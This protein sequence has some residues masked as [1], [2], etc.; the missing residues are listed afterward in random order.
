ML[1]IRQ[2][3]G[4]ESTAM[5]ILRLVFGSVEFHSV[6]I[7]AAIGLPRVAAGIMLPGCF[8]LSKFPTPQWFI[9]DVGRLGF[10]FPTVFAWA[11]VLTEV[12]G[13]FMLAAGFA[14]RLVAL[15]LVFTMF[16]AA[17]IQKADAAMWERLPALFFMLNAWFALVFGSGRFGLDALVRRSMN[18]TPPL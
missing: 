17:F 4:G 2:D 1:R 3:G 12:F 14:T 8:G 10:P 6:W 16:V 15:L 18:T 7:D 9:D 11:A 5:K 13:S